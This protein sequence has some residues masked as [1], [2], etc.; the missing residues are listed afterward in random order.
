MRWISPLLLFLSIGTVS[1]SSAEPQSVVQGS[2][3]LL[4]DLV[5]DNVAFGPAV[6]L[7]LNVRN[8][9]PGA[10]PA[11]SAVTI[12]STRRITIRSGHERSQVL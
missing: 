10:K 5:I 7:N 9:G 3:P 8:I 2:P 6:C 12:N 11:G 1:M 4:P